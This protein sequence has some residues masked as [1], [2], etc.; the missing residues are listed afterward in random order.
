RRFFNDSAV[1]LVPNKP[2]FL[3]FNLQ[4][5]SELW[6]TLY[7]LGSK[8]AFFCQLK[9]LSQ[10][11]SGPLPGIRL[12]SSLNI[13]RRCSNYGWSR[14]C[15]GAAGKSLKYAHGELPSI[16]D[17]G[18]SAYCVHKRSNPLGISRANWEQ[19]SK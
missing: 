18:A 4:I 1:V 3:P 16:L 15:E 14:F 13:Y 7:L 2:G 17:R 6:Q 12:P 19:I 9:C 11:S 5:L 10:E 8:P